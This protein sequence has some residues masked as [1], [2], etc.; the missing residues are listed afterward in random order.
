MGKSTSSVLHVVVGA[1]IIPHF[2]NAV[3]S[4]V[5]NTEDVVFAV[6]NSISTADA[7][8]F[9][10]F[11]ATSE[12]GD[13]V[14]L[15]TLGNEG[16]SK[17]GSLYD[18]YNLAIDYASERD[19]DYLNF[20]QGDCQLMW[21]SDMLVA[22]L[23]E[24]FSAVEEAD[25]PG[26]LCVGTA[27]PVLGKFVGS[28]LSSGVFFD[29]YLNCLAAAGASV[30]DVGIFSVSG[31]QASRFRFVGTEEELQ[32]IYRRDKVPILDVPCV[33]FI[34]WPATVRDGKVVGT[35]VEPSAVGAPILRTVPGFSSDLIQSRRNTDPF[36]MEY[37]IAPNGWDCL[38]PYWPTS[39][40][41][42][43]WLKRRLMAC[44]QLGVNPWTRA[45]QV[46][47]GVPRADFGSQVVP[48]AANIALALCVGFW[49]DFITYQRRVFAS[50]AK[51]VRAMWA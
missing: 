3:E 37:C 13:R 43:K 24:I 9:A 28:N 34:P 33:A 16:P 12:F 32:K 49:Q 4:I 29:S 15:S 36:W 46:F 11:V 14:V 44:R 7:D 48:L 17:T 18:A 31:I 23:D 8:S 22:R 51:R 35:V 27:F 25:G 26:V 45:S 41:N 21:W 1:G 20:V 42:P 50:I 5:R 19:F 40:E 47:D 10:N 39:I 6:Y 38:F 30:A 2:R